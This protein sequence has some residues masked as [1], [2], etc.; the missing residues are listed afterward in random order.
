MSWLLATLRTS[1]IRAGAGGDRERERGARAAVAGRV[2]LRGRRDVGA[3]GEQAD[4]GQ[5]RPPAATFAKT[6]FS[7]VP[8][9]ASRRTRVT[10]T[11]PSSP[12]R[13][14]GGARELRRAVARR[15]PVG[16]DSTGAAR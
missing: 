3:V 6:S 10:R 7:G 4:G 8:L 14:A 12:A 11:K 9:A 16:P 2:A 15:T 5:E 13:R 1:A